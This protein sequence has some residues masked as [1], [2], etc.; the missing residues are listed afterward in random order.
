L[1]CYRALLVRSGLPC[2]RALPGCLVSI[3]WSADRSGLS[4]LACR[5]ALLAA[6]LA[7]CAGEWRQ[8]GERAAA[9][10][11][12]GHGESRSRWT[13][14]ARVA[15]FRSWLIGPWRRGLWAV[16]LW[17]SARPSAWTVL[18]ISGRMGTLGTAS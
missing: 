12:Q 8:G 16:S 6:W 1:P 18:G 11:A 5:R 14:R 15:K 13:G 2:C 7:P 10:V 3:R 9:A 17:A 4:A